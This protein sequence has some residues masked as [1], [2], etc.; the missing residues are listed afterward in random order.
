MPR[1]IYF[2]EYFILEKISWQ[3]GCHPVLLCNIPFQEDKAHIHV[4][5]LVTRLDLKTRQLRVYARRGQ[6]WQPLR[7][8][9]YSGDIWDK[10][11]LWN[12]L[13]SPPPY[14]FASFI[15]LGWFLCI[16]ISGNSN[17]STV[18]SRLFFFSFLIYSPVIFGL[19]AMDTALLQFD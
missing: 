11:K 2:A 15:N 5:H 10:S 9:I 17:D 13:V 18:S 8:K 4:L 1:Q 3:S 16:Y 6:R 7:T 19:M 12:T 14:P